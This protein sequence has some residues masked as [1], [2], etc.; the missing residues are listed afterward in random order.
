[1]PLDLA[2]AGIHF[3]CHL[4]DPAWLEPLAQRYHLFL[5]AGP[6]PWQI[7]LV[8]EEQVETALFSSVIA[9]WVT[10]FTIQGHR[11]WID[12]EQRRARV[13]TPSLA[14]APSALERV[15]SYACM[16]E[17]PQ[18]G[19]G[20]LL[21]AAGIVLDGQGHVFF[22]PS[23]AG[24]STVARLAQGVGQVLCDEAV[25]LRHSAAGIELLSTP[26]WGLGTRLED[27]RFVQARAPL[28]CLYQLIQAPTFALE[29]LEPAPATMALLATEKVATERTAAAH[30]WLAA[31]AAL[32]DRVPVYR[33]AFRPTADLWDFLG[34]RG[35]G[36]GSRRDR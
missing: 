29:Q 15:L 5:G 12:L 32:L 26:F 30:A 2:I 31:V 22:G 7:D 34:R 4:P 8:V 17:L 36:L 6:Q 24:K 25:I 10:H 1:M 27:V 23:G 3:R 9:G 16:H 35:S 18:T 20:L 11:G 33:L 19:Q 14:R 13:S 28:H 21:H